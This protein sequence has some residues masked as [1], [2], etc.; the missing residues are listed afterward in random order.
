MDL[1]FE[2]IKL[3]N[4]AT[5]IFERREMPITSIIIGTKVGSINE[6]KKIKGIS[7][8]VEHMVFKGTEKR[9]QKEIVETIENVGG[10]LNAFTSFD[11]TGFNA[12]VPSKHFE[13]AFDV[14]SD[15][16]QNPIFPEK[17]VEKERRVILEEIKMGHDDP[18]KFLI[19][20]IFECLYA[21][22]FGYRIIGF[23]ESISKISKQD[24]VNWHKNGYVSENLI[25]A[26][27]GKNDIEEIKW[28]CEEN[29]KKIGKPKIKKFSNR[30]I[31]E[32]FLE[33]RKNIEQAHLGFGFH[34]P[35][36]KSKLIFAGEIINTILGYG[37]SSWL[38]QEI[39]EKRGLAY[40]AKSSYDYGRDFG[41]LMI[42]IGTAKEKVKEVTDITLNLLKKLKKIDRK[43]VEEAKEKLTGIFD[44]RRENSL[45]TAMDMLQFEAIGKLEDY[46]K[47]EEKIQEIKIED[48]RNAL[49]EMKKIS[50]V[51]ILPK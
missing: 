44:L 40:A 15:I 22:P 38:F 6:E 43:E 50:K 21:K 5:L 45:Y 14:I 24:L 13:I 34:M 46:Y 17:E 35:E 37:M 30:K 10:D 18:K 1:D 28:L 4:G 16:V 41:Y 29:I 2:K 32:N 9:N 27:V 42:Y 12:K 39:R 11:I 26:I 47:F 19:E 20:K 36:G 48:L 33:K 49:K 3:S 8:F 25:I 31:N 23:K 51:F 7:H